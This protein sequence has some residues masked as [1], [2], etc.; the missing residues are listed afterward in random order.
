MLSSG[1]FPSSTLETAL[2][3][4]SAVF[5]RSLNVVPLNRACRAALA[6]DRPSDVAKSS[7]TALTSGF[8]CELCRASRSAQPP[9]MPSFRSPHTPLGSA[10]VIAIPAIIGLESSRLHSSA[11]KVVLSAICKY[12]PPQERENSNS[13]G[14]R[15]SGVYLS[16]AFGS[17]RVSLVSNSSRDNPVCLE[18]V[19]KT[20]GPIACSSWAGASCLLAPVPTHESAVSPWP[21]CLKRSTSSL[22]PPLK[23]LPALA[24][25]R[26]P[27]SWSSKP[28]RPVTRCPRLPRCCR[29]ASTQ[30]TEQL[31]EFV[32]VLVTCDR[33][34]SQKG[35]HGRKAAAHCVTPEVQ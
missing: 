1:A 21:V 22:S 34:K 5:L 29:G 28:P 23:M 19:S 15:P 13:V 31:G 8:A 3:S 6:A 16:T 11:V 17:S 33:E 24:P 20:S 25:L 9:A 7:A 32:P 30:T 27:R 10:A 35:S 12:S 26:P 18:S 4:D 14:S 2:S